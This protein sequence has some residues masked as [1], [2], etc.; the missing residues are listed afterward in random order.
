MDTLSDIL[1]KYLY[2]YEEK[3]CFDDV[4]IVDN[5]KKH[6][7]D[8]LPDKGGEIMERVLKPVRND[9]LCFVYCYSGE[10]TFRINM[11]EYKLQRDDLLCI[12]KNAI[13]EVIVKDINVNIIGIIIGDDYQPVTV[14]MKDYMTLH[15][16]MAQQPLTHLNSVHAANI[17]NTCR[18]IEDVINGKH[19][20]YTSDLVKAYLK[21]LYLYC[22]KALKEQPVETVTRVPRKLMVL[23]KFFELVNQYFASERQI[24]FYAD[25]LCLDP[26]YASQLIKQASGRMAGDWIQD[27]VILE[28]KLLLLDGNHNVQQVADALNFT[29]QSFFGKYFKNATGMSPKAYKESM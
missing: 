4:T 16:A 3:L 27:R 15:E 28:A 8:K 19:D 23:T 18:Q 5:L 21:A 17:I 12:R 22:V 6:I 11:I 10:I 25:K 24:K 20:N 7:G 26:K 1:N 2:P 29:S 13:V 14:G 9:K